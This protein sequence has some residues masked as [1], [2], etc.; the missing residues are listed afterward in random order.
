MSYKNLIATCLATLSSLAVA[1]ARA[2]S[3]PVWP[4]FYLTGGGVYA[5]TMVGDFPALGRTT[6]IP[7]IMIA[8]KLNF[9]G[10]YSFDPLQ[11]PQGHADSAISFALKSPLFQ[12]TSFPNHPETNNAPT[13]YLDAYQRSNF[14][15]S[16]T[17]GADFHVLL[18]TPLIF[19]YTIDVPS[20]GGFV[21][22]DSNG[23]AVGRLDINF[24]QS[25]LDSLLSFAPATALT[26]IQM[27]NVQFVNFQNS[28]DTVTAGGFHS[29]KNGKTYIVVG[30]SYDRDDV[31]PLGHELAEWLVDPLLTSQA[32]GWLNRGSCAHK[33]E[34]GDPLH[35]NF[36]AVQ[37]HPGGP[38][39]HLE[40]LAFE[41]WFTR[42]NPSTSIH[43]WRTFQGLNIPNPSCQ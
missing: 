33:M 28:G 14:W 5:T 13:Q 2:Q 24:F 19:P 32:P 34:V 41:S 20:S 36:F 18:D 37:V 4:G 21:G 12:P 23:T 27:G 17:G 38:T 11:A 30:F 10:G 43:G 15:T 7:I 22:F 29:H 26:F 1:P 25:H 9:P 39:F 31:V 40:D 16:V 6:R 35:G 8:L 42:G 3:L